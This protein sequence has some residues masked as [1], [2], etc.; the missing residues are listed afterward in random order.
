MISEAMVV[1]SQEFDLLMAKERTVILPISKPKIVQTIKAK[2][3]A[4]AMFQSYLLFIY[5]L[6]HHI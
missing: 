3:L 4:I 2:R 6:L 1:N 5:K